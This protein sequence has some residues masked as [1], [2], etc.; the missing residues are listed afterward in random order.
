MVLSILFCIFVLNNKIMAKDK[1]E[2]MREY[3]KR[4]YVPTGNKIG[5]PNELPKY[6]FAG[7]YQLRC[8]VNG[9][10]YIGYAI[11]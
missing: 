11:F 4:T 6:D 7:I 8:T 2:Y 5:R 1:T 9:K 3:H 10:I